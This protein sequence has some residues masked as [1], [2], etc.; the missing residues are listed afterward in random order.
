MGH[1]GAY[2]EHVEAL[3]RLFGA[4][5]GV[6]SWDAWATWGRLG[7]DSSVSWAFVDTRGAYWE[8]LGVSWGYIL[9]LGRLLRASC[10]LVMRR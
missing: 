10:E 9:G 5:W 3:K 7:A 1:L 2:W 6:S 4:S 8:R